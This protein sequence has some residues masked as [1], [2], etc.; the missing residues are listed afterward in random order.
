[1]RIALI[2][3]LACGGKP[4]PKPPQ[5]SP[6]VTLAK[7]LDDDLAK[8][9][10]LAHR[11]AADCAALAMELRPHV[12]QMKVHAGDVATMMADPM[13]ARELEAA[14]AGYADKAPGRTDAIAK[15]LGTAYLGCPDTETKYRLEKAIADLP[16]FD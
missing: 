11:H 10:E 5:V 2:V 8:L 13:T 9:A 6:A 7:H 15:D 14:L 12:D 3:L 16:T 4:V 1:M